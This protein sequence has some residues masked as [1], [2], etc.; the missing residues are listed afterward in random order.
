MVEASTASGGFLLALMA[1]Q[2]LV[3]AAGWAMTAAM[4]RQASGPEGHFALF[5]FGLA[6]GLALALPAW[7]PA[8]QP[9]GDGA[10]VV[11]AIALH[12]GMLR[13]FRHPLPDRVYLPVLALTAVVLVVGGGELAPWRVGWVAFVIASA[14]AATGLVF[15]VNGRQRKRWLGPVVGVGLAL[16]AV[17]VLVRAGRALAGD[18]ARGAVGDV[19][20][21]IACFFVAGVFNLVQIRL[22]LGRVLQRLVEQSQRDPLTGVA[23]R[24]GL[25]L[26]L[27]AVHRRSLHNGTRYGLLMVDVDH[28][29]RLNDSQGH[30]AG[31]VALRGMA[32]LL[33]TT[34]RT[35]DTVCRYGGEEFCVVLPGC[36]L[37][38]ASGLAE[39]LRTAV[40]AHGTLTVSVGVALVDPAGEGPE[41]AIVR[42]DGAL[43]A[44]KNAGRNRVAIAPALTAQAPA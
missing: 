4:Q 19:A 39:R 40:A 2:F 30:A 5:W 38:G 16:V 9:V 31:D 10:F 11:G 6:G 35:R 3:H 37:A 17:G 21:A 1:A 28:F 36:D 42:A 20:F 24:R 12:R 14:A 29:K 26:T 23:N 18:P 22:V 25:M 27:D 15:W 43:Y 41:A 7:P 13:F 8:L 33:A 32:Q 34:V 44:A